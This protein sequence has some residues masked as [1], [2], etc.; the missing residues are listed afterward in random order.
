VLLWFG[1]RRSRKCSPRDLFS[2]GLIRSLASF[3]PPSSFFWPCSAVQLCHHYFID[4]FV[5]LALGPLD[6]HANWL[7]FLLAIFISCSLDFALSYCALSPRATARSVFLLAFSRRP[8]VLCAVLGFQWSVIFSCVRVR[9]PAAGFDFT[10]SVLFPA[11]VLL[12]NPGRRS[13][14]PCL[15]FKFLSQSEDSVFSYFCVQRLL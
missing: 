1:C 5:S 6:P 2:P 9:S 4:F 14:W 10:R 8:S 3:L 13:F 7:L 15:W 11:P 12:V